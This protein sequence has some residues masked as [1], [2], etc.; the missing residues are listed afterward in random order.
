MHHTRWMCDNLD[1]LPLRRHVSMSVVALEQSY[2]VRL[3]RR[4]FPLESQ[5]GS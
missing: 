5:N 1:R 3:K 2:A 4:N